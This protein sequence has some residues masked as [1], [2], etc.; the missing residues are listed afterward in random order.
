MGD[1]GK[2]CTDELLT[3]AFTKYPSFLKARCV[4]DKRTKGAKYG[5]LSFKNAEDMV[6]AL[7]E[8]NGKYVANRPMKLRR[9]LYKDRDLDNQD[10]EEVADLKRLKN[11]AKRG[12]K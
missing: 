5:F 7:K 10:A 9:S 4:K 8:M 11:I 12:H 3:R 2:D 1:L 6:Q